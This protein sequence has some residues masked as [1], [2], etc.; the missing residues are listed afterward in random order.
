M[1]ITQVETVFKQRLKHIVEDHAK[2]DPTIPERLK[3]KGV[4]CTIL[5]PLFEDILGYDPVLDIEYELSSSKVHGQRF[6]FLLDGCFV[7][8]AKA[9]NV[10]LTGNIIDQIIKYI[11]MN[12]EINYGMLTNGIQYVFFIQKTFIEKVANSGEE[13]IGARRSVYSVLTVGAEDDYFVEIMRLFSKQ[14]YDEVFR[15]I[16]KYAFRQLVVKKGP[17]TAI[18]EDKELDTY[19]K[20][21]IEKRMD[22]KQGK[23]LPKIRSGEY[24]AGQKLVYKDK[25]IQ[26]TIE[27]QTDGTVKLPKNGIEVDANAILETGVFKPV[28]SL[29]IDWHDKEQ[30]FQDPKD[31]FRQALGKAKISKKYYFKECV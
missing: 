18:A 4:E 15:R 26:I 21:L 8:E 31:I 22:F 27:V 29:I 7:V 11:S 25:Y 3:E 28:L 10:L 6:D 23:Y 14:T 9:L 30:S 13:I 2:D 1:S 16:A 5:M 20:K 17:K 12:D 24:K 19:I